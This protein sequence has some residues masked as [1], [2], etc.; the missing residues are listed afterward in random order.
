VGGGVLYR[1]YNLCGFIYK[2]G[3]MGFLF[4]KYSGRNNTAICFS[5]KEKPLFQSSDI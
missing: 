2:A 5:E 1:T 3:P 4:K